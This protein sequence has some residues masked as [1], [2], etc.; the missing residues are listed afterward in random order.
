[1]NDMNECSLELAVRRHLAAGDLPPDLVRHAAECILCGEAVETATALRTLSDSDF[2]AV[3]PL[4]RMVARAHLRVLG[5]NRR[6]LTL[7]I[8]AGSAALVS[9]GC[10]LPLVFGRAFP[11]SLNPANLTLILLIFATLT[12]CTV[13]QESIED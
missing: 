9:A 10:S 5:A 13:S 2:N 7:V 11:L 8:G 12:W 1:M 4:G 6:R 3:P